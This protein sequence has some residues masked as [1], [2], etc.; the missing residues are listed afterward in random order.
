MAL[1]PALVLYLY[2]T[3]GKPL[4]SGIAG[5]AEEL[6]GLGDIRL[7]GGRV[8]LVVILADGAEIRARSRVGD[9]YRHEAG[10]RLLAALGDVL[11]RGTL[12]RTQG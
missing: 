4:P 9:A 11:D 3:V 10:S 5:L 1:W 8:A 6:L 2:S 7:V 12:C